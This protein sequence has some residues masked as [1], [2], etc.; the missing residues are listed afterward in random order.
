[1][2]SKQTPPNLVFV[3]FHIYQPFEFLLKPG[4]DGI[5][6]FRDLWIFEP[7]NPIA[8]FSHES[9]PAKVVEL[10]FKGSVAVAIHFHN[11]LG[12]EP[13]KVGSVKES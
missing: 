9:V 12:G 8:L 11:N 6:S 1:M 5:R 10:A 3:S 13:C 2:G 4:Q 7:D